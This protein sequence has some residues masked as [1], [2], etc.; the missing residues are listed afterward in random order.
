MT[1]AIERAHA[2]GTLSA[3]EHEAFA[4]IVAKARG[5]KWEEAEHACADFQEAQVR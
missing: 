4:E 5:E 2:D 3:S 1:R